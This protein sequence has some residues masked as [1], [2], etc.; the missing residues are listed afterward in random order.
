VASLRDIYHPTRSEENQILDLLK[1]LEEVH[2]LLEPHLHTQKVSWQQDETT[3]EYWVSG[4]ADQLKQVF[5]NI[6]LNAI[7]AM[8]PGGGQLSV[9]VSSEANADDRRV[10]L[11]FKD[12][13]PGISTEAQLKIFEPFYTTKATGTGLG[14]AICYEIVQRH[15]GSI[16]VKSQPG[17]GAAFTITLPLVQP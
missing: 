17:Q 14:L 1:I 16:S 3:Q 15:Q 9:S 5:L 7:E 11:I 2:I 12:S 10:S 4:I 8:E 6:C 13:G